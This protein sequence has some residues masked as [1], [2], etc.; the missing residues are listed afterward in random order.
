MGSLKKI[1]LL[2]R[3]TIMKLFVCQVCLFAAV[4][5]APAAD[6]NAEAVHS[7][8]RV[9]TTDHTAPIVYNIVA[10]PMVQKAGYYANAVHVVKR[11][12]EA[13]PHAD[14]DYNYYSGYR[15]PFVYGA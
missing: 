12:A 10:A 15:H 14:A 4:Y 9:K 2:T 7:A 1:S 3:H 5:T 6:V 13:K 11:E 8:A